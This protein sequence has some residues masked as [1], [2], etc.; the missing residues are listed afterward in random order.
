MFDLSCQ[1]EQIEDAGFFGL[2]SLGLV[3]R[4]EPQWTLNLP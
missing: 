2:I 1:Q 3:D 4:G